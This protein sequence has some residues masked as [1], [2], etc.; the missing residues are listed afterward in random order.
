MGRRITSPVRLATA[1]LCA[2]ALL[3]GTGTSPAVAQE[4]DVSPDVTVWDVQTND[5]TV[6]HSGRLRALVFD[7]E[8]H[9]GRMFVAGKFLQVTSP[10]G[11]V[12]DQP[13]LAAFDLETG[14]MDETFR[15][16]ITGAIYAIAMDDDDRMYVGGEL[17]G[18]VVRLD[19]DTGVV[20]PGFQPDIQLN[21]G[22]RAVWDVEIA[23]GEVYVAG[24]FTSAQGTP[25]RNFAKYTLDGQLDPSWLPT[26]D[27]DVIT[28]RLGG[29][30]VF[31]LAVDLDRDRVYASGKFGGINGDDTAAYFAVIDPETGELTDDPQGL[32]PQT[33]S[34][35]SAFSMWQH[36][37]QFTD[38][39]VYLGGQGHQTLILDPDTLEP[40]NS[41]FTNR[42]VGDTYAGG[43]TQVIFVGETTVWSGC[44]CWGSV[45]E[46]PLG[47]YNEQA[48]GMMVYEEYRQWVL[49]FR[50]VDPF[51]QQKARGAYGVDIAT[52]ELTDTIFSMTG[53]AGAWA[54]YEDSNGRL[55]MGGQ[56]LSDPANGHV[57]G[58]L[59]R[60][61]FDNAVPVPGPTGLRS[62]LQT[63]E[64][65]VL[66]W[67][68]VP[69][70]D[71]YNVYRDGELH[72]VDTDE[73]HTDLDLTSATTYTYSVTSVTDG[74]ESA[75]A[76]PIEVTTVGLVVDP[77]AELTTTFQDRRRA[78]IRW[79]PEWSTTYNVTLDGVPIGTDSDGWYTIFDLT[80]G[81]T[82]T[83][84]LTA[85]RNGVVSAEST[86][87]V[88]T[89]N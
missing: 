39:K 51:G 5:D 8:E 6:R 33:L 25:A 88:T 87:E 66:N 42:G 10:E 47:S 63:R 46:Y 40:E 28:P 7:L 45:G 15:P 31:S 24:S 72:D 17:D 32:P 57:L 84:G 23:G 36:D 38:T 44:H 89:R 27:L 62:T 50:D 4:P 77:P 30:L 64:R 11:R 3:A 43:D 76:T 59:V 29:Q 22:P 60:I 69:G 86:V 79:E 68:R 85:E 80:P 49:D 48:D 19:P 82:Y 16:E 34:H 65:A 12:I 61:N 70:A 83:V 35:R 9:D 26:A 67:D 37:V 53:Q 78:V 21:W 41:F 18:G 13:Y 2:L 14:A 56:F 54:L 71:S 20:D 58:G 81:T 52:Q 74:V 73:W 1:A 75:P 55:W